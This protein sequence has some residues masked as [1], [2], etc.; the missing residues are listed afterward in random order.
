MELI[1]KTTIS[2]PKAFYSMLIV[3][4]VIQLSEQQFSYSANWGKR[5]APINDYTFAPECLTALKLKN[6]IEKKLATLDSNIR[7][8]TNNFKI[9][10]L[11]DLYFFK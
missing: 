1:S 3:F 8:R 10:L 4:L 2:T 11:K 5:N 7:V 6:S 9:S